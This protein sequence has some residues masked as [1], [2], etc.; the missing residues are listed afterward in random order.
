MYKL[1]KKS[2]NSLY[3]FS[4][5]VSQLIRIVRKGK[6]IKSNNLYVH[7]KES[8]KSNVNRIKKKMKFKKKGKK[9]TEIVSKR[10]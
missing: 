5:N 3:K 2:L 9:M 8:V 6:E 7:F 10:T 4:T 1:T